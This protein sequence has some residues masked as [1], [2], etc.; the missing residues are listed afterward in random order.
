MKVK[1]KVW[2]QGKRKMI[3]VPK[4]VADE[5]EVGEIVTI[6]KLGDEK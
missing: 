5:F 4:A 6:E 3:Q 2:S 1:S